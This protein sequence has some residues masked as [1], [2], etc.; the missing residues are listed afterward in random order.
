M[1]NVKVKTPEELMK[2]YID[3]DPDDAVS[4]F[5][6]LYFRYHQRVYV[7]CLKRLNIKADAEDVL[8]KIFLKLHESKHLFSDKYKFEQWIFV[9]AKTSVFDS[10][11]KRL[12]DVRKI[13]ALINSHDVSL[14]MDEE[15]KI[16][17]SEISTLNDDQ[18][19]MLE[20]KYVDDLSYKEISE[21][22]GK[23]EVS[24]RKTV[25]RLMLKLKNGGIV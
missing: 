21:I 13:E 22:L 24:I 16:E 12:S 9:I 14:P 8:Q 2:I 20:L 1:K 19:K 3:G 23:T 11:R 18:K 7:Y 17:I 6:E 25:S 4:A 5:E 10:L 15:N